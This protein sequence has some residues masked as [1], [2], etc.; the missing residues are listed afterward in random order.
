MVLSDDLTHLHPVSPTMSL[1]VWRKLAYHIKCAATDFCLLFI[2]IDHCMDWRVRYNEAELRLLFCVEASSRSTPRRVLP[3]MLTKP[4]QHLE[5][6]FKAVPRTIGMLHEPCQPHK[7]EY[8]S[9]DEPRCLCEHFFHS[10]YTLCPFALLTSN[11][12]RFKPRLP[13][14]PLCMDTRSPMQPP[15][16]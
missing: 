9:K 13:L 3:S 10:I 16:L 1:D 7:L 14:S 12:W 8:L 15:Y 5:Q 11:M 4:R 6:I 2:L